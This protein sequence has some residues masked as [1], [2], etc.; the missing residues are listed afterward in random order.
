MAKK[1]RREEEKDENA[2]VSAKRRCVDSASAEALD[3]FSQGEDWES[4]GGVR[5]ETV[6]DGL[7]DCDPET[8]TCA[9]LDVIVILVSFFF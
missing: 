9:V 3:I 6:P 8:W 1:S 7:S 2:T 5:W 4:C